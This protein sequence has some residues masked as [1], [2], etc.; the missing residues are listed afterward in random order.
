MSCI[1]NRKTTLAQ[2]R[3]EYYYSRSWQPL[4]ERFEDGIAAANKDNVVTDVKVQY[5]WGLRYVHSPVL[6]DRDADGNPATG[7]YGKASQRGNKIRI[8]R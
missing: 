4:E 6:R 3:T 5:V 1:D 7:S 8:R 2:D